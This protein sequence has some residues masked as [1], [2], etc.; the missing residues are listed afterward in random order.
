MKHPRLLLIIFLKYL[1]RMEGELLAVE[2][3]VVLIMTLLKLQKWPK[4]TV[5]HHQMMQ[6]LITYR[7]IKLV[8]PV[9]KAQVAR[10]RRQ[11]DKVVEVA[12]RMD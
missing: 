7:S 9:E 2:L 10:G 8:L 3:M 4:L 1:N 11:V 5:V 12:T 6:T